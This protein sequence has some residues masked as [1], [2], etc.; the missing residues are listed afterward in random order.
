MPQGE[1]DI[2]DIHESTMLTSFGMVRWGNDPVAGHRA[3]RGVRHPLWPRRGGFP[4]E[5]TNSGTVPHAGTVS[6]CPSAP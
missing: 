4:A 6:A 1:V 5:A 3:D 2:D